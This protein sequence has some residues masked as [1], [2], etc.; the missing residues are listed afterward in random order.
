MIIE[1]H[2]F[3][4]VFLAILVTLIG[5]GIIDYVLTL[6]NELNYRLSGGYQ[7]KEAFLFVTYTTLGRLYTFFPYICLIGVL[8]AFGQMADHRELVVIESIG[9]TKTQIVIKTLYSPILWLM[10]AFFVG[11]TF[12]PKLDQAGYELRNVAAAKGSTQYGV[13]HRDRDRFYFLN[14]VKRDGSVDGGFSV[15]FD[16]D[17]NTIQYEQFEKINVL[18]SGAFEF[19]HTKLY[20]NN[21]YAWHLTD[22]TEKTEWN[23]QLTPELLWL[24]TTPDAKL[25]ALKLYE[26]SNYLSAQQ[27]RD[28][29][30]RLQFWQ[31]LLQPILSLTLIWL[32]VTFIFGPLRQSSTGARMF[33]GLM[34]AISFNLIQTL[35]VPLTDALNITE[36]LA[37]SIPIWIAGIFALLLQWRKAL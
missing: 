16:Y 22:E 35:V 37:A 33:I 28:D 17:T 27:L 14:A 36:I 25:S 13:W 10:I 21:A 34:I 8:F 31:R 9:L 24:L 29:N 15:Y 5:I 32:A 11:E 4:T 6:L 7:A 12:V 18:P 19:E 3:R 30:F 2:I 1:R 23:T 26:Y 20:E